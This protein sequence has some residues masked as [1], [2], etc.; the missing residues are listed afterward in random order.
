PNATPDFV[1][2]VDLRVATLRNLTGAID[3]E[4][5][6]RKL[7]TSFWRDAVSQN[8]GNFQAQ[9][10][11]NGTFFGNNQRSAT[12]IAFGLKARNRLITYGY[13]LNEYPGLNKTFAFHSFAANAQ[14]QP[15]SNTI[16]DFSPD[17]IGALA[18]QADKSASR[19]LART[20]V[21]TIATNPGSASTVL[22]FSSA[23]STQAHADTIL[24]NFGATD[25][26]ML[27]GGGSTGLIVDG[28]AHISTTRTLPHAIAIYADK[29]A[30][31]VIGVSGKCL[32]TSRATADPVQIQI[33]NCNGSPSQRWS[34]R[35]GT[36]QAISNQCLSASEPN[37]PE[38]GYPEYPNRTL[39][40]LLPC[41]ET[42]TQQWIFVNG[43]FQ[44]ISG[45]CLDALDANVEA[46]ISHIDNNTQ[47]QLRP[48]NQSVTQQWQRID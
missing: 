43:N 42:A 8:S 14:I 34:L 24:K 33:A 47:V 11:I 12:D 35:K 26:A 18:A 21:G 2:V 31:V 23:A 17:V 48:C 22:F 25:I 37:Q 44:A 1:T 28:T 4:L 19:R 5:I 45:Q 39:V 6:G 20:F 16:F 41:T 38:S 13:G 40:Q 7:L 10:V 36:L 9:V 29:P 30:G 32:D 27:D 46:R 3:G 15:Y